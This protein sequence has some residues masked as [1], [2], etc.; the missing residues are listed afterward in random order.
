MLTCHHPVSP[1]ATFFYWLSA[2]YGVK[3]PVSQL[4]HHMKIHNACQ[5]N[6]AKMLISAFPSDHHR[7][8]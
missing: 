4:L 8:S 5:L 6:N 7:L 3:P 2:L 1:V